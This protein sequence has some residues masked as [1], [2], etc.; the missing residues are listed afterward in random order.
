MGVLANKQHK[1]YDSYKSSFNASAFNPLIDKF[2]V[3]AST[4]EDDDAIALE[5][6][7]IYYVV[8]HNQSYKSLDCNLKLNLKLYQDLKVA[9]NLSCCLTKLS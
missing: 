2:F 3:K 9:R 1:T 4:K 5:L 6:I 8:K 7:Q